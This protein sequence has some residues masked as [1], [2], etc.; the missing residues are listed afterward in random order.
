MSS[1]MSTS[2]NENIVYTL[3][4]G[5]PLPHNDTTSQLRSGHGGGLSLL[6]DTQLIETLA[7]FARERIPERVVHA[8]AAGARGYFELTHDV[9]DLTSAAFL[10]GAIGKRTELLT[11]ISTVG[12]ERGSADTLRDFRGWAIKMK[13]EEGNQDWVFNNQ[14]VF[15]VRDP[16]KFPSLNRSHKR[17]PTTNAPN[18]DMFWDFHINNQESIHALMFLFS[19]RGLPS[20]L[21]HMNGYSGHTYT[22]TKPDGS[23]NYIKIHL[24][25]DQGVHYLTNSEATPLAGTKPD[26]HV[27]DLYNAIDAGN[28]P[29]WTVYFQVVHPKDLSSCPV[30]IFDMTKVLPHG[31]FPLR[32]VGKIVFNRNPT[33]YFAEI[34]QAAFSPS[35]MVPG[36]GPSEDPMLQARMFAYPD[37]AR[38]RLG[39]NYQFLP[40]NAAK[41]PVYCPTER[42]GLM[43]FT[44]NYGGDP[45][46]VRTKIKPVRFKHADEE[47]TAKRSETVERIDVEWA[48]RITPFFTTEVTEE[49]FDQAR[50]LWEVMAK[51]KGA[52]DRFVDN[53]VAH[54]SECEKQWIQQGVFGKWASSLHFV[55]FTALCRF[56]SPL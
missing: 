45:N 28:Y 5:T 36:F 40:T 41:N 51:Q 21:R 49:D 11:R 22:L 48:P 54:V 32:P 4:E 33:N 18:A 20:T 1:K 10:T 34:E 56:S 8:K 30:N 46:Y 39:V 17:H 27:L 42:D 38:Y 12:P 16:I 43:N 37:A 53:V 3:A 31:L 7:H 26:L 24:I 13:T 9:S 14:P 2:A 55:H 19:D 23:Y 6:Q 25:S 29:S 15:F 50:K 44:A 52:Q 47:H 35:N